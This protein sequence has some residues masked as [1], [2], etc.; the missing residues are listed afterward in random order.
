MWICLCL[1]G[2]GDSS[3]TGT[4]GER[5]VTHMALWMSTCVNQTL[6]LTSWDSM[7]FIKIISCLGKSIT[8]QSSRPPPPIDKEQLVVLL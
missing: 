6:T 8:P 2:D 7:T 3:E 1:Y 4:R 5:Q